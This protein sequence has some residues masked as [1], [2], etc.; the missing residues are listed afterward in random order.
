MH[1]NARLRRT[2][3]GRTAAVAALEPPRARLPPRAMDAAPEISSMGALSSDS[4]SEALAGLAGRLG[5]PDSAMCA[6]GASTLRLPSTA[7]TKTPL[8]KVVTGAPPTPRRPAAAEP[9]ARLQL[10]VQHGA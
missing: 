4:A 8:S 6:I 2:I 5:A 9:S 3:G 1:G 10:E 7:C